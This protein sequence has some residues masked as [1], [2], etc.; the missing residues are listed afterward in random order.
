MRATR[1]RGK[2]SRLWNTGRQEGEKIDFNEYRQLG[3]YV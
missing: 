2:K 1:S 3:K